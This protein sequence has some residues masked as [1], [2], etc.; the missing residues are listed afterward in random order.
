MR[1]STSNDNVPTGIFP[2]G[3]EIAMQITGRNTT[4]SPLDLS[5]IL[6]LGKLKILIM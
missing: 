2:I 1:L 6:Q 3:V 4:N 5:T